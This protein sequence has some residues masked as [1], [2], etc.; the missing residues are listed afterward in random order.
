[1]E[2]VRY[3]RNVPGVPPR[4][5]IDPVPFVRPVVAPFGLVRAM[6][7]F[8]LVPSALEQIPKEL[9]TFGTVSE[10]RPIHTVH[11]RHR[12][13]WIRSA[14]IRPEKDN[15]DEDMDGDRQHRQTSRP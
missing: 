9:V 13:R 3:R 1:M 5:D 12:L 14:A 8:R 15:E 11:D 7:K 6:I 4:V 10:L 2:H